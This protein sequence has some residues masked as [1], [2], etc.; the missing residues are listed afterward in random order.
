M[1]VHKH[2]AEAALKGYLQREP[3]YGQREETE[4]LHFSGRQMHA[5]SCQRPEIFPQH[6]CGMFHDRLVSSCVCRIVCFV[7]G[8]RNRHDH[9]KMTKLPRMHI[10]YLLIGD[11]RMLEQGFQRA[12]LRL[13]LGVKDA[14]GRGL[15]EP[16]RQCRMENTV[17][18]SASCAGERRDDPPCTA[19]LLP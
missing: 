10:R 11:L 3:Q 14:E 8:I 16:W 6:F 12:C 7:I 15:N 5:V 9:A 1:A 19:K 17:L 13:L 4:H 18:K 2:I